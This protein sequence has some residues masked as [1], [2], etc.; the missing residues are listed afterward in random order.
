LKRPAALDSKGRNSSGEAEPSSDA[1]A[2]PGRVWF[3]PENA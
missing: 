3:V 2:S 1:A